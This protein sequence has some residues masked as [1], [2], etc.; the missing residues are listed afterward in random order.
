MKKLNKLFAIL[1]AMAMVLSLGVSMAFAEGNPMTGTNIILSKELKLAKGLTTSADN[2]FN[3]VVTP[4]SYDGDTEATLPTIAFDAIDLSNKT[5]DKGAVYGDTQ[6]DIATAFAGDTVK[7]GV[8][9]Y[10]VKEQKAGTTDKGITY[11]GGKYTIIVTKTQTGEIKVTIVDDDTAG[12][13]VDAGKKEKRE[14]TIDEDATVSG[15]LFKNEY[16]KTAD[17]TD[18][19]TQ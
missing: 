19:G 9:K 11:D 10:E 7:P 5:T 14:G 17:G 1:V 16:T 4:L 12:T 2:V 15:A 13:K 6:T 18:P 8:Y 3:F